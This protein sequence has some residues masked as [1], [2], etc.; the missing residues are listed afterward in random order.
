MRH[1]ARLQSLQNRRG[2]VNREIAEFSG[3]ELQANRFDIVS[4]LADD[5]A[6][7]IKNPLNAIVINLEVLKVRISREDAVGAFDRAAVIEHEVRRLHELVDRVLLLLRP[8][9]AETSNLPVDSALGEILPLIQAQARLARNELVVEGGSAV[10]VPVRRD[11]FKFALLAV[12]MA[13]HERL[14]EGGGILALRCDAGDEAV[15]FVVEAAVRAEAIPVEGA[16]KGLDAAAA[17]AE[18]LL[19]PSGARATVQDSSITLVLPRAAA[20]P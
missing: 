18:A 2:M 10:F 17:L 7:E 11:A 1:V 12:L 13:V 14:G 15:T 9:R 5:L 3:A 6:H 16:R 19:V 4:R 8:S 20:M